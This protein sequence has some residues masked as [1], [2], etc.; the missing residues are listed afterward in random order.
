MSL[1]DAEQHQMLVAMLSSE[2]LLSYW[3]SDAH[4]LEAKVVYCQRKTSPYR[5]CRLDSGKKVRVDVLKEERTGGSFSDR[6]DDNVIGATRRG[7]TYL[8]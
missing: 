4:G 6:L 2:T 7:E 5:R 8:V 3:D 1:R